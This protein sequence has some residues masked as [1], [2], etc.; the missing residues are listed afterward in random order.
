MATCATLHRDMFV[1][2]IILSADTDR[3]FL[4]FKVVVP[5]ASDLGSLYFKFKSKELK[6]W[7]E[8]AAKLKTGEF[9]QG[10]VN[11]CEHMQNLLYN[12]LAEERNCYKQY[13]QG[14]YPNKRIKIK[15]GKLLLQ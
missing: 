10:V 4:G 13:L 12:S 15:A 1:N 14:L 3:R 7:R 11:W 9:K 6:E 5:I 2:L 8:F